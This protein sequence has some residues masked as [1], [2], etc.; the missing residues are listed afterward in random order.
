MGARIRGPRAASRSQ[1][2]ELVR[3]AKALRENPELVLPDL[4]ACGG[5]CFLCPFVGALKRMERICGMADSKGKLEK[6]ARS[7]DPI[8]KAYAATLL[9]G[10]RED[11]DEKDSK[12]GSGVQ[13]VGQAMTPFG[14]AIYAMRG[15]ADRSKLI[16][17]Q[18]YDNPALRLMMVID[19]VRKK[20]LHIYSL[21][22]RMIC[23]GKTP[24]PPAEFID[25][26]MDFLKTSL[27]SDGD[28]YS[29]FHLD[30]KKIEEEEGPFLEIRWISAGKT[31]ALCRRCAKSSG[32]TFARFLE[33]MAI[34][35]PRDDFDITV[36]GVL[37]C[38][39]DCEDCLLD[40]IVPEAE[41][42]ED[43]L[44]GKISDSDFIQKFSQQALKAIKEGE[45]KI[46]IIKDRCFGKDRKA[47]LKALSASEEERL[48]LRAI[49]R[50]LKGAIIVEG[51]SAS[52]LLSQHWKELGKEAIM[53]IVD[54]EEVA[55]KIF[56]ESDVHKKTAS[57]IL[58]EA[59]VLARE[60]GI[61]SELPEY[62]KLPAV[63][64]F[65]DEIARIF[66]T[67]GK[68]DAVRAVEKHRT[69]E[70]GVKTVAYAFL[71]TFGREAS[72]AWIYTESE[73]DFAEY[74]KPAVKK[75]LE[76]EPADYHDALQ[77]LLRSTGSTEKISPSKKGKKKQKK[78]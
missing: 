30:K 32:N 19:L 36:R 76:A 48:A 22:D 71:L 9:L 39:G 26:M 29:C 31:I 49:M 44:H 43:Y 25:Y 77:N 63:A 75:L 16:G 72:K 38:E 56:K 73:K 45:D 11:R 60:K 54:D 51:E 61:I 55:E 74:I 68:N 10:I 6:M 40:A 2:R 15:S 67:G 12:K 46:Y 5:N 28:T 4:E 7:G 3:K 42:V 34:P 66:K 59:L 47:F 33:R 1:Q 70:T 52:K 37:R 35:R 62:D 17:V 21:K 20:K 27:K 24:N 23:T 65:A 53:A 13:T 41:I 64:K 14:L 18:H 8:S 58:K 78:K 69:E 50:K 57:Q